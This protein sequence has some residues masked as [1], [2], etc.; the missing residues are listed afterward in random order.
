LYQDKTEL[1]GV[2]G[3]EIEY[4]LSKGMLNAVYGMTV[5]DI[6]KDSNVYE[7]DWNIE[8]A[9]IEELI[10]DYNSSQKRF[11]YYPW[12]VFVTAYARRNL[13]YGI[14]ALGADYIYSDTDSLKFTNQKKHMKFINQYNALITKKV[15]AMCDFYKIDPSRLEP[16]TIEGIKKPIGVWEV[17]GQY[18]KFK[19]LGAK[20]YMVEH[21]ATKELEL[22][23]SG[24]GKDEGMKYLKKKYGSN[25]NVLKHFDDDL[26]IPAEETGK[27]VHTYID[28]KC[29]MSITDYQGKETEVISK[30]AVHLENEAYSLSMTEG[31]I[32]FLDNLERGYL[33]TGQ[34]RLS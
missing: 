31:Y 30:S 33:Y 13:W 15:K 26:Y 24:L 18:S 28:Y 11:L 29:V 5:T 8:D 14:T 10:E 1:K 12:G 7:G 27:M 3:K 20:R 6:V 2:E 19:T 22:T 16:T 23:V 21:A 32:R 34:K 17:D 4:V 9:S 25:N